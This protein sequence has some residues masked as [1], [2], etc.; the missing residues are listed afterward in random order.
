MSAG[1]KGPLSG[2]RVLDFTIQLAGPLS[3]MI[4]GELGAEVIKIE[5]PGK[6]AP[7]RA[8]SPSYRGLS[9]Y[10]LGTG[11]TKKSVTVNLKTEEG[12]TIVKQLVKSCDVVVQNFRPGVVDRLGVGY[13]DLQK[14]NDKLVYCS[15]AGFDQDHPFG[16]KPSFDLIA[17]ALTG[18]VSLYASG[19]TRPTI[20]LSL[21]DLTTG[22]MASHAVLAALYNREK[23]GRGEHVRVSL[24]RSALFLLSPSVQGLLQG[25]ESGIDPYTRV[26][27]VGF[28][29]VFTDANGEYFV[30]EAPDDNFFHRLGVIPELKSIVEK[31]IYLTK[32]DRAKNWDKLDEEMQKAFSKRKRDYW[33]KLIDEAGIPCAPVLSVDDVFTDSFNS[34]YLRN[35]GNGELGTMKTVG[36]PADFEAAKNADYRRPPRLGEHTEEI[37]E[38]LGYSK[39][40]IEELKKNGVV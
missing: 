4:L 24:F 9:A 31:R 8:G 12:L 33:L 16:G 29:G 11:W 40:K 10:F 35:V 18:L 30:V 2:V 37:L 3:T 17:Q 7:E 22:I 26:K 5:Q 21:V 15:I 38:S 19:Q 1:P 23:S 20:P 32:A 13:K 27:H 14:I 36:Y 39:A 28:L 6:G 25:I 34:R